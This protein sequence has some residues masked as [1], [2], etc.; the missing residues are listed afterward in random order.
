[1]LHFAGQMFQPGSWK[2]DSDL[3]GSSSLHLCYMGI[4]E[5]CRRVYFL[6]V[7]D[8]LGIFSMIPLSHLLHS[9]SVF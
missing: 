2:Q 7:L 3:M 8:P 1:M 9:R 6:Q 5:G 4:L